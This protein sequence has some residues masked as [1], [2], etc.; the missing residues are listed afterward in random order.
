MS[1]MLNFGKTIDN[2]MNRTYRRAGIIIVCAFVVFLPS[3]QNNGARLK[4]D[5][6]FK[7]VPWPLKHYKGVILESAH[8]KIYTTV[9]DK[10]FHRAMI[11][12]AET[13]Y[14]RFSSTLKIKPKGKMTVYVFADTQQW[15]AFTKANLGGWSK[16]LLRIR[17]GG[18]TTG[19][20]AAFY[21]LGRYPTLTVLAHELFHLYLNCA[22]GAG[23]PVWLN[24]GLA[25]W[26]ESNEWDGDKVICTPGKNLFRQQQ[27]REAINSHTLF[28]LKKLLNSVPRNEVR[29][30]Y[31]RML[32]YYAQ[33]WALMK[34]LFDKKSGEWHNNFKVL[35]DD[36]G[37]NRIRLRA[38]GYLIS[39][40]AKEKVTFSEAVFR[41]YI[42]DDLPKFDE[43]F[44]EYIEQEIK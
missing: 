8:Y 39:E 42:E 3:C 24:E 32:T 1:I 25:C 21:Y 18:Y 34:F 41:A 2:L 20:L 16:D 22:G 15:I 10:V 11:T 4:I 5:D 40:P 43:A 44:R 30:S 13:Q 12:L 17:S 28:P 37:T 7:T 27:L 23:I 29:H 19:N 35:L 33:V 31:S 14:S 9:S 36:I 6:N 26:F 38:S